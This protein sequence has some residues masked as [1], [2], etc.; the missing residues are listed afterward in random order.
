MNTQ[1]PKGLICPNSY[2]KHLIT[3][4]YEAL[5]GA[6]K[7]ECPKCRLALNM[8]V[9]DDIKGHIQNMS[10]AEKEVEKVRSFKG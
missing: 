7:V 9:P 10:E 1:A 5:L 6:N 8:S 4:T 3:F 2:C